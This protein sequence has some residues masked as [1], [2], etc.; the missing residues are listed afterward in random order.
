MR[1]V[2]VNSEKFEKYFLS[3]RQEKR[4]DLDWV[5]FYYPP[6][7]ILDVEVLYKEGIPL[8]L[9]TKQVCTFEFDFMLSSVGRP[10]LLLP[11]TPLFLFTSSYLELPAEL[12]KD[13]RV[14]LICESK[15]DFERYGEEKQGKILKN[16]SDDKSFL[17]LSILDAVKRFSFQELSKLSPYTLDGDLIR[18]REIDRIV[19]KLQMI[20]FKH[21]GALKG[22]VALLVGGYGRGEGGLV[23]VKGVCHP[24]NN[25]DVLLVVPRLSSLFNQKKIQELRKDFWE[26][27]V[28][29]KIS[30]DFGSISKSAFERGALKLFYYDLSNGHKVLVGDAQ[31]LDQE[32]LRDFKKIPLEEILTLVVNRSSALFLNKWIV[33]KGLGSRFLHLMKRHL[34]KATVACGDYF[35]FVKNTFSWSYKKKME[36]VELD[37][38]LLSKH[39]TDAYLEAVRFR[40]FPSY[41]NLNEEELLLKGC[42]LLQKSK[43][44]FGDYCKQRDIVKSNFKDSILNRSLVRFL[45]PFSYIKALREF[46]KTHKFF[47]NNLKIGF[48]DFIRMCFLSSQEKM[49][50]IFLFLLFE[51]VVSW[52]FVDWGCTR[53]SLDVYADAWELWGDPNFYKLRH[54]LEEMKA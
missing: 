46:R 8:V 27:E 32:R 17:I 50:L 5:V 13:S 24:S 4:E 2:I 11:R 37:S 12:R 36:Y 43:E 21:V 35:L 23:E 20:S 39:F 14:F 19:R 47:S 10:D 44:I 40:F 18:E 49:Y 51:D 25:L 42:N 30:I 48:F 41:E 6:K 22:A 1:G 33:E 31:F 9:G 26:F 28:R 7:K 15:E 29:E 3:L 54:K 16:F 53:A 45:K 52:G 38:G 34:M